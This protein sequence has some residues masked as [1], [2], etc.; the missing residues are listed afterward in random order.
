MSSIWPNC[1]GSPGAYS[2]QVSCLPAIVQPD[3]GELW[4]QKLSLLPLDE[5]WGKLALLYTGPFLLL[6]VCCSE[7]LPGQN[8]AAQEAHH[9]P[10]EEAF[11]FCSWYTKIPKCFIRFREGN[12]KKKNCFGKNKSIVKVISFH[13]QLWQQLMVSFNPVKIP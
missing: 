5:N 8:L 6:E 9:C 11:L 7:N 2:T 12:K 1:L 13:M 10:K 3:F 4:I